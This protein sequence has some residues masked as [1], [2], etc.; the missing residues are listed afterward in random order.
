MRATKKSSQEA[1]AA[2]PTPAADAATQGDGYKVGPRR[3]PREYQ[4]KRGQSGNP[5][6][7]KRKAPNLVPDLKKILE[8]ALKRE[9]RATQ[10]DKTLTLTKFE[11]G[12]EQLVN[13]YVKGDR[14]ARKEVFEIADRIGL[15]L[16]GIQQKAL[17]EALSKNHQAM[18][19]EYV[20]KQYDLVAP[21]PV[22]LAPSELLDDDVDDHTRH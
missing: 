8:Q 16:L 17:E 1:A 11:A 12:I 7:A 15:D 21:R 4:W 13:Q 5:K 3:P 22:V 19:Y 9:V 10:G 6:G 2:A 14:H 18:L 20:R